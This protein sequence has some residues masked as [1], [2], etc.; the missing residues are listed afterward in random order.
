MRATFRTAIETGDLTHACFSRA[1]SLHIMDDIQNAVPKS[2]YDEQ[3]A[4]ADS[5]D[6]KLADAIETIAREK[7]RA[8]REQ[9]SR[10]RLAEFVR[11]VQ[12]TG[13]VPILARLAEANERRTEILEKL[14]ERLIAGNIQVDVDLENGTLRLPSTK[15]F[16][17]HCH[18]AM[19]KARVVYAL[20]IFRPP[21]RPRA[22]WSSPRRV[23]RGV[24]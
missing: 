1:L 2:T 12:T 9:A 18:V 19:R 24:I 3:K 20:R 11:Y 21:R 17:G 8:D 16:E 6:H 10:Q 23:A 4:R 7:D 14:R 15:L 5:L 13:V 22:T